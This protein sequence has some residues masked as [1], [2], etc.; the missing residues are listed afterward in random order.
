MIS[1]TRGIRQIAGAGAMAGGSLELVVGGIGIE[2]GDFHRAALDATTPFCEGR[3]TGGARARG[4]MACTCLGADCG[5][6]RQ[7]AVAFV[8][9]HNRS[10]AIVNVFPSAKRVAALANSAKTLGVPVDS[11]TAWW[12]ARQAPARRRREQRR[13]G[14]CENVALVARHFGDAVIAAHVGLVVVWLG[15]WHGC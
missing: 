5:N 3:I 2:H 6:P 11:A 13:T 12:Q 10:D 9:E 1:E 7:V 15:L 8:V 4:V 14:A